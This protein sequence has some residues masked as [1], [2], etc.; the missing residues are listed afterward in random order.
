M[1][2]GAGVADHP[3]VV[4]AAPPKARS[5]LQNTLRLLGDAQRHAPAAGIVAPCHEAMR[6]LVRAHYADWAR[7]A[8]DVDRLAETAAQQRDL[9]AFVAEL[10]IDPAS[11]APTTR[12]S[13]ISTRTT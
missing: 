11:A 4:A 8:D 1:L 6:P 12:T 7:R 10:T 13:R 9:R 2:V 3:E 5:A